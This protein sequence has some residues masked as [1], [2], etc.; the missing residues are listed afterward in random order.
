MRLDFN[1]FEFDYVV[2]IVIV[3]LYLSSLAGHVG[4]GVTVSNDCVIGAAC[5]VR[6][7]ETLPPNTVIYGS[8]CTRYTKTTPLQVTIKK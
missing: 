2:I 3:V 4:S 5:E 7:N 8:D 6:S 1:E